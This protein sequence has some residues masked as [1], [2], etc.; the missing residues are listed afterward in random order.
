MNTKEISYQFKIDGMRCAACA[1][2]AEKTLRAL[3]N[4]TSVSINLA[5]GSSEVVGDANLKPQHVISQLKKLGFTATLI[6]ND[7][8][9]VQTTLDYRPIDVV[10][11]LIF[12]AL[13]MYIGMS[14]MLLFPLPLPSF[15]DIHHS[16]MGFCLSQLIL[17]LP[18]LWVGRRFLISGVK[19]LFSMHP[20]MDSLVALGT[21]SAFIYSLYNTI[22]VL[23]GQP[24]MAHSLYFESAAVVL[25]LILLG[26]YLEEKSKNRAK[27][28]IASL[29]RLIPRTCTVLRDGEPTTVDSA[30]V[31]MDELV[32]CAAGEKIA[33][34]GIV[35][36]GE[37]D[38]DES[39]LTGESLPVYKGKNS[40]VSGGTI[41]QDGFLKIRTTGAGGATTAAQI[42]R[43]VAD[44]QQKKAPIARLADKIS[45]YFVPAVLA[46]AVISAIVWAILGKEAGFV[47]QIFV[48]V[49]V[50]A[51]PC[52]LGLATPIAVMVASGRGAKLGIL[53]RGGHVIEELAHVDTAV[54]DKTGTITEGKLRIATILDVEGHNRAD[55]LPLCASAE[56]GSVHPIAKAL[57]QYTTE[58][59]IPVPLPDSVTT[60]AG[61]GVAATVNQHRVV[62]GTH[63]F[64]VENGINCQTFPEKPEGMAV[65]YIAVNDQAAGLI[66]FSD[67][68]KATSTQA[69]AQLSSMQI[70]SVM[71]TGD[72]KTAAKQIAKE[73]G[74]HHVLAE[75]LPE[76]KAAEVERLKE[77]GCVVAMVGDGINDAPALAA[78]RVGVCVYG[79][80]DVAAE[81][82]G[83]LLMRNDLLAFTDAV[84]LS[85]FTMKIIRENLFWAFFYNTIGIPLAAGVLS[86]VGILLSPAL[87]GIMM[88]LSSLCVVTNSL[89][90]TRFFS[91]KS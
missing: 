63:R 42:M 47:L 88:A 28:A 44:A 2:S 5:L 87:A 81:V 23:I 83:V 20:N 37:G 10:I 15:I 57:L 78:A 26:K 17:T 7:E 49:L 12:G 43:L 67:T 54:F 72:N 38:V 22:L 69:V 56:H 61:R 62:V 80:T 40:I 18:V 75:I 3:P 85:R 46:I 13:V 35:E 32:L 34:D 11:G 31:L 39:M 14:H 60:Q 91:K 6:K 29:A 59:N 90:I 64:M 16:P 24:K 89:R 19:R 82:A 9:T 4:V 55:W 65:I 8:T 21:G 52:S 70:E 86:P 74:I 73:S 51:C 68:M 53:F 33:V 84:A 30:Q 1:A 76:G 77:K 27:D 45:A 41:L 50:V 79:G 58:K 48:S 25:A 71:I 66:G 36:E